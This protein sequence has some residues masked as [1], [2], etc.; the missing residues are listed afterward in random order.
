MKIGEKKEGKSDKLPE[1]AKLL[2]YSQEVL[3]SNS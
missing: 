2:S 3:G 1:A